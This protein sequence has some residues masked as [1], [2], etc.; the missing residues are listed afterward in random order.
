MKIIVIIPTYN[1]KENINQIIEAVLSQHESL[2]VL[3]VDDN[4]PD[5]TSGMV[6][7]LQ[8]ENAKI[9]LH[10]RA[11]K[12][13]LGSAYREGYVIALEKG[14]DY[15]VQMDADFSHNPKYLLD[16]IEQK[17]SAD[18]II[19]SRYIKGI[20]VLNW[21]LRR[22]LLSYFANQ[23]AKFITG[24]KVEDLTA[25]FKFISRDALKKVNLSSVKSNGYGFQIEMNYAFH[26]TGSSIAETPILFMDR[27]HGVSKMN[28]E[29]IVEAL[30]G[31]W[32][33][34]FKNYK[35]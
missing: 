11:G 6:Q 14:A 1:E 4:S 24:V 27:E 13:G 23:Y 8:K 29:I 3:I 30:L 15:I 31:V 33:F 5:D 9:H 32:T 17:D 34:R 12:L 18:V 19:G 16:M 21:P 25:G 7:A 28:K 10:K 22:I 35:A 20:S 2:E 26:V